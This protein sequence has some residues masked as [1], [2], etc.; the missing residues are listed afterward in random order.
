[1]KITELR[2]RAERIGIGVAATE[3]LIPAITTPWSHIKFV[4][5]RGP[6][7]GSYPTQSV[8]KPMEMR[9]WLL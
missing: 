6:L 1:M 3:E 7:I 9:R 2:A 8:Q 4:L 5:T